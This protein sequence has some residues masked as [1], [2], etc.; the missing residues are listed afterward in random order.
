MDGHSLLVL[1]STNLRELP[2]EAALGLQPVTLI[3]VAEELAGPAMMQ[4]HLD[5]LSRLGTEAVAA[6]ALSIDCMILWI[7]LKT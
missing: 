2:V 7:A 5:P 3:Q 4:Q 1:Q 6:T